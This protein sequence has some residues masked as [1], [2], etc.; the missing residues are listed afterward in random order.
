MGAKEIRGGGIAPCPL[1][2]T[3]LVL[4]YT[5]PTLVLYEYMH[6]YILRPQLTN[7]NR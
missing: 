7:L 4:T 1:L 6:E 2:A 5:V 3:A